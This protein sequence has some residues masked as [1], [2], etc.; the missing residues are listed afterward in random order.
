MPKKPT[1]FGLKVWVLCEALTGFCLDF[2][3]YTGK[4]DN[5]QEHGL[6]HRVV[7]DLLQNR[8]EKKNSLFTSIIIMLL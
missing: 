4:T 8:L 3:I 6:A 1:R 2:Q 7:F 5:V